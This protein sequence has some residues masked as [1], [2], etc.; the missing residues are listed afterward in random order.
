MHTLQVSWSRW[1]APAP[2]AAAAGADAG[3]ALTPCD[4]M[5]PHVEH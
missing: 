2:P 5:Q 3:A 1:P 4:W